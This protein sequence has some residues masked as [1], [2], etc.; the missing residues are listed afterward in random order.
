MN[1]PAADWHAGHDRTRDILAPDSGVT[2]PTIQVEPRD[3]GLWI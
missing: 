1:Q 3:Q 2:H